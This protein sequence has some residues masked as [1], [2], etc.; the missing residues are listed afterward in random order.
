MTMLQYMKKNGE[1]H[2][3]TPTW[4]QTYWNVTLAQQAE[5]MRPFFDQNASILWHNTNE[6]FTVEEY[7]R[8]NCE[9]P[10]DWQGSII[11]C[12]PIE[13]GF[14]TITHVY[15]EGVSFHVTSIFTCVK[16][17]ILKLEEYWSEDGKAPDWRRA[18]HIGT[19]IK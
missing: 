4:L 7:I 19:T 11:S 9:Y 18:L 8:A 15:G 12:F 10:G 5:H 16:E 3:K 13:Q 2:M 14:I 17:S 1:F 6:C